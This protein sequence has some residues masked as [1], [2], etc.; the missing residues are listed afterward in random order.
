M[1]EPNTRIVPQPQP[2]NPPDSLSLWELVVE[3]MKGRDAY[4]RNKYGTVLSPNNGR[5]FLIDMYQEL[6]DAVVYLRGLLYERD[7]K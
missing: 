3:D 2:T 4:G 5:D 7:G 6:L 1:T